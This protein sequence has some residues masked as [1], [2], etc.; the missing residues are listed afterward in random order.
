MYK[1]IPVGIGGISSISNRGYLPTSNPVATQCIV[2][3]GTNP[4]TT[5]HEYGRILVTLYWVGISR[6]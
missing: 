6:N 2:L 5:V 4:M 3:Y 1:N